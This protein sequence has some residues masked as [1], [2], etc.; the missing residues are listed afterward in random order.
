[1]ADSPKETR[2]LMANEPYAYREVITE[3]V[4][5]LRPDI[6]VMVV[7]P[8]KLDGAV[9]DFEPDIVICSSATKIV[10]SK[11]G[12][13]VELYPELEAQSIVSIGGERSEISGIQLSDLIS[14]V[15]GATQRI[16]NN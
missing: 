10:R 3:A 9:E 15:D 12:I 13:W 8:P 1:M 4:R 14:I 16:S 6:E 7:E 2:L 11:V 5:D